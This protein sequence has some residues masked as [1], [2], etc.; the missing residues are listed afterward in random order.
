EPSEGARLH[1]GQTVTAKVDLGLD[2]GIVKLRYYWYPEASEVLVEQGEEHGLVGGSAATGAGDQFGFQDNLSGGSII[3]LPSLVSTAQEDPPFGGPLE[4][5]NAAIGTMR[6]LAVGEVSRGRL[7]GRTAFDEI[8]LV[9]EPKAELESIE[10]ETEKPWRFGRG[11]QAASYEQ[12][13]FLG[14]I[15]EVPVVG[16]FAD[17]IARSIRTAS[18]GT[19]Y[20]SSNEQVI[21]VYPDG[22]IQLTGNGQAT[23]RVRNRGKEAS[24]DV[25]VRVKDDPNQPPVAVAGEDRTVQSRTKVELNG[26]GSF[27]PEG[28]ALAYSWSQVRGAKVSLLDVNMPRASYLA[29]ELSDK[30]LFRF[31]LRVTDK[32]GADSLPDFVDVWVEP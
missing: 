15:V 24:L 4:V 2:P 13:D 9:V 1:S 28:T 26:L 18:T 31:K 32:R 17:G 20:A 7:A 23:L 22:L 19:T 8:L 16:L 27:D 29:P 21:K 11:A 3:A 6:L 10:F 14:K 12:V 25:D 30:R 5:P